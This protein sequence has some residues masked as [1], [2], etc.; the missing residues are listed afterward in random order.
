MKNQNHIVVPY[1]SSEEVNEKFRN[2]IMLSHI[3][4]VKPG[5]IDKTDESK[6]ILLKSFSSAIFSVDRSAYL[7]R[8]LK[9]VYHHMPL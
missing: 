2:K 1:P 5:C 3:F 8:E 9:R 4:A 7:T 6:H